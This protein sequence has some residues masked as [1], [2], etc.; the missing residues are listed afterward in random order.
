MLGHFQAAAKFAEGIVEHAGAAGEERLISRSAGPSAYI[1]VHGPTP[2]VEAIEQAK[3]LLAS[4]EGDRKIEAVVHGALA[5]LYAMTTDFEAART[6]YR[7][8]QAILA[9]LGAGIDGSSTS[10]DSGRVEL[11][12]GDLE[13]AERELRR[14]DEALKALDERYF[15]STITALLAHVLWLR[16]DRTGASAFAKVA[17]D[18]SDPDDILSQVLWQSV[19]AKL[20]AASGDG[21]A[22]VKAAEAAVAIAAATEEIG[23]QADALVG[24]AETLQIAGRHE[25]AG[26][27]LKE[28][29]RLY[30][31]KGD[32]ASASRL[33]SELG[34]TSPT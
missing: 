23:L 28:A 24:L 31:L 1:L 26:P 14:D 30:D 13:A 4:V 8:G 29:L 3:R 20:I 15:R 27:P 11:L 10:I 16:G 33:R 17:E 7:R 19:R 21:P 2:V 6:S 5:Q 12:A 9:E 25:S 22:G 34:A 18:I 32:L